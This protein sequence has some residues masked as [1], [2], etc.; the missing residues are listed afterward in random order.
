MPQTFLYPSH[1]CVFT[2]WV[3]R[4]LYLIT[5]KLKLSYHLITTIGF[6][7]SCHLIRLSSVGSCPCHL[8]NI[9]RAKPFTIKVDATLKPQRGYFVNGKRGLK[10]VGHNQIQPITFIYHI[11]VL[12]KQFIIILLVKP[13]H[14]FYGKVNESRHAYMTGRDGTHFTF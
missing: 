3:I 2:N 13:W 10:I 6:L 7:N 14:V 8:T 11:F 12:R 5:T 4:L 1:F 9:C